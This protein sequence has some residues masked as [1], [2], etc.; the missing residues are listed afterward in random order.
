MT[1]TATTS[2]AS[3]AANRASN[4]PAWCERDTGCRSAAEGTGPPWS[5]RSSAWRPATPRPRPGTPPTAHYEDSACSL[6]VDFGLVPG[7]GDDVPVEQAHDDVAE[8]N[9][10]GH[11]LGRLHRRR[12]G[13][14]RMQTGR[15]VVDKPGHRTAEASEF[16]QPGSQDQLGQPVT[17]LGQIRGRAQ[18]ARSGGGRGRLILPQF[19][20]GNRARNA[21]QKPDEAAR[22]E[23]R[24]AGQHTDTQIGRM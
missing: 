6:G 16:D 17:D 9:C 19:A 2:A 5:P 1:V 3:S 13:P 22:H 12:T 21:E 4:W 20:G 14:G 8:D 11:Y 10:S 18:P 15:D 7:R 24:Q 23:C